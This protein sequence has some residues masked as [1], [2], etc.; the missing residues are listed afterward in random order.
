MMQGVCVSIR[1][2]WLRYV[3][4]VIISYRTRVFAVIVAGIFLNKLEILYFRDRFDIL[5]EK[6]PRGVLAASKTRM[7]IY[8]ETI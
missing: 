8:L 3:K 2:H 6:R 7:L 4:E 1:R 5:L